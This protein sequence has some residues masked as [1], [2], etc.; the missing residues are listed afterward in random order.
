MEHQL[1]EEQLQNVKMLLVDNRLQ[2]NTFYLKKVLLLV[3]IAI[4]I[5][6]VAVLLLL[7]LILQ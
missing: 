2:L 4:G 5:S 6:S 3:R 7:I 1:T